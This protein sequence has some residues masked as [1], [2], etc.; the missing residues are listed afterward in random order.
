[1]E[2]RQLKYFLQVAESLNFTEASKRL[3]LTQSTISQQIKQLEE[4]LNIQLF[5]R[6]EKRI[7]LTD[8]GREFLPY[9]MK[10]LQDAEYGKQR[11]L[12]LQN[13]RTGELTIGVNYSFSHLLTS[14][15]ISFLQKYPDIKLNIIYKPVN[16]LLEMIKKRDIDFALS[17]NPVGT[18]K[19]IGTQDLFISPLSVIV[20][21]THPL[22]NCE[23]IPLE[24]IANYPLAL[25]SKGLH[26]RIIFDAALASNH[27]ELNPKVEL[28]EVNMLLDLVRTREWITVLSASTIMKQ[29]EFKAIS[30]TGPAGER[31]EMQA[32]L[33]YLKDSYQKFAAKEFMQM[34]LQ[35]T[36]RFLQPDS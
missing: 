7:C 13:I 23:S 31:Y 10:V 1:M 4:E 26:A 14:T 3:Y 6:T 8:A 30:L 32:A 21:G 16:E 2:L 24:Q 15:L 27:I 19:S 29:K 11:L 28:N 35:E 17:Y 12:D 34:L 9:A 18:E 20:H 33:L 5:D 22:N 36:T 25:P